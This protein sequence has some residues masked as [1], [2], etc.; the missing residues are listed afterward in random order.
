MP[1]KY[2]LYNL[3]VRKD[4]RNNENIKCQRSQKTYFD[5][6]N[7]SR[8]MLSFCEN[9]AVYNFGTR[10]ETINFGKFNF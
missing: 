6:L 10:L 7:V 2:A 3:F 9:F 8:E 5:R 4:T 1:S